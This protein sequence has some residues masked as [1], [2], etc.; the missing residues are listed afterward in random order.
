MRALW[1]QSPTLVSTSERTHL[2]DEALSVRDSARRNVREDFQLVD[3]DRLLGPVQ[4][5][6]AT[7]GE[8]RVA[9]HQEQLAERLS[10]LLATRVHPAYSCYLYYEKGDSLALHKDQPSWPLETLVWLEGPA[11]PLVVHPEL[12]D[13]GADSLLRLSIDYAGHPP[14]GIPVDL[15][16]GPL[17]FT[18]HQIPHHRPWHS[19]D[20]PLTIAVFGFVPE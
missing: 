4:N 2:R 17:V 11:G 1:L 15:S 6:V 18:G 19:F 3:N 9:L 13:L 5:W 20:E 12:Q 14:G 16:R 10:V 8:E 7:Q